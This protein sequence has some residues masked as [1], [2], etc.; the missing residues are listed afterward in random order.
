MTGGSPTASQ[1][2]DTVS[3]DDEF[4]QY[5]Y[6]VEP[7][8]LAHPHGWKM[9]PF[10]HPGEPVKRRH[11]STHRGDMCPALKKGLPCEAGDD[12]CPYAHSSF[13]LWLHPKRFK[14]KMCRS[15]AACSRG[16][17]FFAHSEEEVKQRQAMPKPTVIPGPAAT[18]ALAAAAAA[19]ASP[20]PA[21]A[22]VPAAAAMTA[23]WPGMPAAMPVAVPQLAVPS[24]ASGLQL[25]AAGHIAAGSISSGGCSPCAHAAA[26]VHAVPSAGQAAEQLLMLQQHHRQLE[27]L[28]LLQE[29]DSKLQMLQLLQGA[30]GVA[31]SGMAAV[32]LG[33]SPMMLNA[34]PGVMGCGGAAPVDVADPLA[35]MRSSAAATT[36]A[37]L[38]S[39]TGSMMLSAPW[40]QQQQVA[41]L[42]GSRRSSGCSYTSSRSASPGVF[43]AAASSNVGSSSHLCPPSLPRAAMGAGVASGSMDLLSCAVT[44]CM[45]SSWGVAKGAMLM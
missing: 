38:S 30:P 13:E 43:I 1:G 45:P 21:P 42:G 35:A 37:L 24:A 44:T 33:S 29:I 6:K 23:P 15:G 22:A 4:M 41:V 16:I 3:F 14:T 8:M 10:V 25:Q 27:Q 40:K 2:A 11:P 36:A 34:L 7:C 19:A 12:A 5:C 9:C 20:Q 28:R 18:A 32:Q 31:N 39:P 17:C 26:P